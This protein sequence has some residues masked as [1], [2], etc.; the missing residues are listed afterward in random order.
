MFVVWE[1][2]PQPRFCLMHM[3]ILERGL[4][5]MQILR[6]FPSISDYRSGV[7]ESAFNRLPT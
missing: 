5:S 6:P 4:V 7:I 3:R 2:S 1:M